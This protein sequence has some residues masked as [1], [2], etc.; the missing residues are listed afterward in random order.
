MAEIGQINELR[1]V[2]ELDFGIYLDGGEHG[3]I[4][5]PKR[6]IPE[7]CKPEDI[8]Q[9]FIYRDS[10][11]RLIA[12]TEEPFA[13]VGDFAFLKAV[14]VS[15]VGAFLDWGLSKD[16]LIPYREQSHKIEV[17]KKYIVYVYLDIDSQ[18][19][20]ASSKIDRFLDNVPPPFKP[21]E[22]VELFIVNK[23]ELGY[24]AII[25][26]T[27]SGIIYQNEVFQTI[28]QGEKLKGFIK[29]V[30]ED[31]KIDLYLIK[32]GAEQRDEL[33]TRILN[34]LKKNGGFMNITDKSDPQII[35]KQ[36]EVSKKNYKIAIGLLYKQK[37]I[38]LEDDGIRL[39]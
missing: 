38:V 20:V 37:M 6:Y 22:E 28:R 33:S 10:E 25:N 21:D 30:R 18:R 2:K 12:T 17:G 15:T 16:L 34:Y 35:Y 9:A 27:H 26:N 4:L 29:K 8:I 24:K 11:D 1:I 19:I 23:T 7:G 31:E 14:S 3:E 5:M 32:K 39:A 36:F 13:K